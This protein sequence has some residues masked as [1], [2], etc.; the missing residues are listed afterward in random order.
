[1]HI[2]CNPKSMHVLRYY[3]TI[4]IKYISLIIRPIIVTLILYIHFCRYFN[5]SHCSHKTHLS[6]LPLLTFTK[7]LHWQLPIVKPLTRSSAAPFNI[8]RMAMEYYAMPEKRI[9]TL[10][11]LFVRHIGVPTLL[12]LQ[13]V[14]ITH[15]THVSPHVTVPSAPFLLIA[16]SL[17]LRGRNPVGTM[18]CN[19]LS[20]L[21]YVPHPT[22]QQR[23]AHRSGHGL[24][25]KCAPFPGHQH[26]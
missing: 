8:V 9:I 24:D 22:S 16:P 25:N 7:P 17:N 6:E 14:E 21:P 4:S 20:P 1:M 26:A 11:L 10:P 13:H 19:W 15:F 18:C 12:T 5:T 2:R 3:F 23:H